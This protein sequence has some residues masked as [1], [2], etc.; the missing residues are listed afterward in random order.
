MYH[1]S[2]KAAIIKY[3]SLGSVLKQ[4]KQI[5]FL[6]TLKAGNPKSECGRFDFSRGLSPWLQMAFFLLRASLVVLF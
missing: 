2:A 3:Y 1:Q 5:Y 6:T 4:R